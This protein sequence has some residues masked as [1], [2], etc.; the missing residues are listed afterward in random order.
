[1]TEQ[2]LKD[3]F[4]GIDLLIVRRIR[5]ASDGCDE[6]AEEFDQLRDEIFR[7]TKM[8]MKIG[9]GFHGEKS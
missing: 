8:A 1:M 6:S 5:R 9:D 7:Q 2:Q 4:L 3:L